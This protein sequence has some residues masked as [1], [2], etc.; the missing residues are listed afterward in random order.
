MNKKLPAS[1][2]ITVGILLLVLLVCQLVGFLHE[3]SDFF[4]IKEFMKN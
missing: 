3:V 4:S 2:L 1:C